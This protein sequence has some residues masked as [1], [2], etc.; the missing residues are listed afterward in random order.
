MPKLSE[1]KT[2]NIKYLIVLGCR[3]FGVTPSR[4]LYER[5]CTALKLV[6]MNRDII[7]VCSGGQGDN[8]DITEARAMKDFFVS[9][10]VEESRIILEPDSHS[11]YENFEF[12]KEKILKAGGSIE[13][14]SAFVTNS[15]HVFRSKKIAELIGYK[16]ILEISA[17]TPK[18]SKINN[19]IREGLSIINY[20]LNLRHK[21]KKM[22]K[23]SSDYGNNIKY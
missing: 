19:Y 5:L 4:C 10:G 3:L 2:K 12:S 21:I 6:K 8:E 14:N 15:F 13:N 11:T 9:N 22:Q 17:N 18:A 7:I 1:L 20:Y 23:N 16:N